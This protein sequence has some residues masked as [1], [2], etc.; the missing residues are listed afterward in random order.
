[1]IFDALSDALLS[2]SKP[3][4]KSGGLAKQAHYSIAQCVVVLC[5][6]CGNASESQ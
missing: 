4:K 2:K 6:Y 1:M 5:I 3:S